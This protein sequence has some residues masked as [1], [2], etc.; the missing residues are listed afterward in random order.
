MTTITLAWFI[1]AGEILAQ[2]LS[3]LERNIHPVIIILA[4]NSSPIRS[5]DCLPNLR[6]DRHER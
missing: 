3:Q 6:P 2:S 1:I 5:R 4:Y